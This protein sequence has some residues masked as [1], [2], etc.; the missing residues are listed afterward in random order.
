MY[1]KS[2]EGSVCFNNK[3][4]NLKANDVVLLNCIGPICIKSENWETL[5]IHFNG[6]ISDAYFQLI[7]DRLGC[8]TSLQNS[9]LIPEHIMMILNALENAETINESL[10][11]CY[12]QRMLAELLLI[13]SNFIA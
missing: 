3:T 6:N 10:I 9:T 2:G 4:L 12:I 5:W 7:Y 1:I 11:S 8:A 13:S